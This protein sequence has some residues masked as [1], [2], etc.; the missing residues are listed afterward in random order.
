[1]IKAVDDHL[2][3]FYSNGDG[4]EEN[5]EENNEFYRDDDADEENEEE[6]DELYRDDD[7]Y[8]EN[9]EVNDELDRDDDRDEVNEDENDELDGDGDADE[10]KE[11]ENDDEV[12]P[13]SDEVVVDFSG[14]NHIRYPIG[15]WDV[16]GVDDFTSV[17]TASGT[18]RP[19]IST[20]I[21][22]D[23]MCRMG[24]VLPKCF[25][26]AMYFSPTYPDGLLAARPI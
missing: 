12:E 7:G 21:C 26:V 9:E 23:G 8:E 18:A 25:R 1:L 13:L 5:E 19:R 11:E 6:N 2:D 20:M 24:P 15:D 4:D 17:L 14:Q 3:V 16:S 10:E 22:P